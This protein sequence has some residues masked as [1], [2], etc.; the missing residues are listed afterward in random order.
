MNRLIDGK[1][2][3][4]DN[5]Y[6]SKDVYPR[7]LPGPIVGDLCGLLA[8]CSFLVTWLCLYLVYMIFKD[9]IK[10]PPWVGWSYIYI[11]CAPSILL[12]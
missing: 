7:Q 11:A 8:F 5:K 9:P 2:E 6:I 10:R 1:I 4:M 12:L 3:F